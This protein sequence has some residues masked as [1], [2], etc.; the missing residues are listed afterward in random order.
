MDGKSFM[1]FWRIAYDLDKE[2]FKDKVDKGGHKYIDHLL[3]VSERIEDLANE[4]VEDH[5]STLGLYY[6]K[7]EIVA[8]LHDI[9]EDTDCTPEILK[10]KGFDDEIINAVI[11]IT[12]KKE[13][14]YYFD[15]IDRV[16]KND[17]AKL[18]KIYDLE[19][20]MDI[21]RLSQFGDYEQKRL[22]KY[23]Y[24]WKYLKGEITSIQCNNAI[25]PDR[26]LR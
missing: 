17:L 8:L 1:D 23:W 15:F 18:V 13:E 2:Y 16:K 3:H 5:K 4:K 11:A 25:H 14:Q 26:L 19:D 22:K 7:A 24:C 6:K 9:L 10:E 21:K 12:R 20:N